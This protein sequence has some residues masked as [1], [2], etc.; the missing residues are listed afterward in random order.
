M[1]SNFKRNQMY[2][3]K[4]FIYTYIKNLNDCIAIQLYVTF[5]F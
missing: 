1:P 4:F 5:H 3:I 2:I